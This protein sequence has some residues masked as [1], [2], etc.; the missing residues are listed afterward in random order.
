MNTGHDGSMGTI[1]ANNPREAI[2]RVENMIAMGGYNL[3]A[4]TVR[5][6]IAGA[7]HVILQAQRLRD[8]SRRITHITEVVGMEGEVVI[9]QDLIVYE[10]TGEDENGKLIGTHK[11][12]GMRPGFWDRARYFG[13]EAELQE[14]MDGL[15]A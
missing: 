10:V 7:V 9:L 15:A 6:Q 1:H 13:L 12:T 4:K 3:P 2:S 11:A 5:E 8:G 14:A